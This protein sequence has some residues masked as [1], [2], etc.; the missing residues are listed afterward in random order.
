MGRGAG[1]R[2]LAILVTQSNDPRQFY[3]AKA[4]GELTLM[5]PWMQSLGG[6]SYIGERWC[7]LHS[8]ADEMI[9]LMI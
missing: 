8:T 1:P 7:K 9:Q 3:S 2:A 4:T 5:V 6:I